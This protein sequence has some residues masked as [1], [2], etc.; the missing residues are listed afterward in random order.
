LRGFACLG[1]EPTDE[2]L[3]VRLLALEVLRAVLEHL[4]LFVAL[5][6][7]FGTMGTAGKV[8]GLAFFFTLVVGA[9]TS[10]IS[11]LEVVVSAA[12]DGLGWTRARATPVLG[13][14][15]VLIG[16]A[17]AFDIEVLVAMD[18][19]ANKVF[20]IGGGLGLAVFTGWIME[21]PASEI[22]SADGRVPRW[23]PIWRFLLRFVVP[24]VLFWVLWMSAPGTWGAVASL[25]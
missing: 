16:A 20:L 19:V 21:D 3:E 15:A 17:A 5:P 14:L 9:L 8:V 23:F 6:K 10:A 12:M 24:V 13:G 7:A 4:T 11:L 25:F 18:T 1:A 2:L 22:A